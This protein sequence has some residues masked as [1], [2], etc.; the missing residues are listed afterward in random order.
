M[1]R[2]DV[3]KQFQLLIS[4]VLI[5]IE[6][7]QIVISYKQN[8]QVAFQN[9]FD[10]FGNIMAFTHYFDPSLKLIG[11]LMTIAIYFKML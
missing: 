11:V 10:L 6:T 3:A 2:S 1:T 4:I 9:F 7:L 5:L 8:G